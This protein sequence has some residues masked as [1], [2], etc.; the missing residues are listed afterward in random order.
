MVKVQEKISGCF[1][2]HRGARQARERSF[3]SFIIVVSV[4]PTW[5]LPPNYSWASVSVCSLSIN[6]TQISSLLALSH[7]SLS[8][9]VQFN[10]E[11][12]HAGLGVSNQGFPKVSR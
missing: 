5:I 10:A 2:T 12:E 1:R 11:F 6:V 7:A 8:F 9:E 4:L 3:S